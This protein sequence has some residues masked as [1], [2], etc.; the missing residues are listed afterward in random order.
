MKANFSFKPNFL[1]ILKAAETVNPEKMKMAVKVK[2][3]KKKP[4]SNYTGSLSRSSQSPARLSQSKEGSSRASSHDSKVA[5]PISRNLSTQSNA[6][7]AK[8]SETMTSS[9]STPLKKAATGALVKSVDKRTEMKKLSKLEM[10]S[11][12]SKSVSSIRRPQEK[13]K[14]L[15]PEK[16]GASSKREKETV[17]KVRSSSNKPA[18]A[19]FAKPMEGL[20]KKGKTNYD[21]ES[22]LDDF[23]VEDEDEP[24][25][26]CDPGFGRPDQKRRERDPG[27]D[28][29][30]IWNL[31][32][33][34]RPAARTSY[35]DYDDDD[36][37]DMEVSGID[38]LQE[39]QRSTLAA[40]REDELMEAEERRRLEEKRKRLKRA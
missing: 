37:N 19:P 10:S 35:Y 13:N 17:T 11:G 18:P 34:G 7:P 5:K 20:L 26:N 28:R 4:A 22:S 25:E 12:R 30:E 1:D 40:R 9:S 16:G 14:N 6:R 23:I 2:D 39:E 3:P 31:F 33:R 32:R 8:S 27:Y 15:K 29:E 36:D 21:S 38:I 24:E